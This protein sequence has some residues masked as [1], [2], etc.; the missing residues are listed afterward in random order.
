MGDHDELAGDFATFNDSDRFQEDH[1][2]IY[3]RLRFS[4]RENYLANL[5]NSSER[6][7]IIRE[8]QRIESLRSSFVSIGENAVLMWKHDLCRAQWKNDAF[9]SREDNLYYL[10]DRIE[11]MHLEPEAESKRRLRW[12]ERILRDVGKWKQVPYPPKPKE[13]KEEAVHDEEEPR[14]GETPKSKKR[15]RG[16]FTRGKATESYRPR[17]KKKKRLPKSPKEE[18]PR[19]ADSYQL[20][21]T[22][23]TLEKWTSTASFEQFQ[24]ERYPLNDFLFAEGLNP[25]SKTSRGDTI[26]YFHLPANNMHW[27][28]VHSHSLIVVSANITFRKRLDDIMAKRR[29]GITTIAERQ[30]TC[31]DLLNFFATSTGPLCSMEE[32]TIPRVLDTWPRIALGLFLVCYHSMK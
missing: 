23:V 29:R 12:E 6:D 2:I 10:E 7:R 32:L 14:D 26:R 18:R 16:L 11:D 27:I 22:Q 31:N 13:P 19:P 3:S 24:V 30:I 9:R 21:V 28:E 5:R 1:W 8:L 4:E 25:L 20:T 17:P 15:F